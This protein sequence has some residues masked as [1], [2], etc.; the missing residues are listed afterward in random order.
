MSFVSILRRAGY[1]VAIC[2]GPSPSADPPERCVLATGEHCQFVEGADVV[3]SGLGIGSAETR[4]VLEA[5]RRHHPG[6]PLVV[7][8]AVDELHLYEDLLDGV[9][10]VVDPVEPAELLTAVEH[11]AAGANAISAPSG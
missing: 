10:L 2:P 8:G 4:A 11:A 1:S 6:K 9:H 7:V 3:V 5:L